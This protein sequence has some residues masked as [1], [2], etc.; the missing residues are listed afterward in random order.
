VDDVCRVAQFAGKRSDQIGIIC[1]S[2]S[3]PWGAALFGTYSVRSVLM[4]KFKWDSHLETGN[5]LIDKEHKQIIQIYNDCI[6]LAQS[7]S[8][9]DKLMSRLHELHEKVAAHFRTEE[10]LGG[11]ISASE[12]GKLKLAQHKERHDDMLAYLEEVIPKLAE[13]EDKRAA[14]QEVF[15]HIHDWYETH[16]ANEDRDFVGDVKRRFVS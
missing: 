3:Y 14:A 16:I 13:Q 8:G 10:I 2:G 15:V 7:G 4:Q 5:E 9:C 6:E 11:C 12:A 1:Q